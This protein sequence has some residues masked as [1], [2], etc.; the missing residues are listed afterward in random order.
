MGSIRRIVYSACSYL[1]R[2]MKCCKFKKLLVLSMLFSMLF[3]IGSDFYLSLA[4]AICLLISWAI[5]YILGFIE[6]YSRS[7]TVA[8]LINILLGVWAFSGHWLVLVVNGIYLLKNC[9]NISDEPI[10]QISTYGCYRYA[11]LIV[12]IITLIMS[13][14][15]KQDEFTFI[16]VVSIDEA[17]NLM[18]AKIKEPPRL[19]IRVMN[20]SGKILLRYTSEPNSGKHFLCVH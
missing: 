16:K 2:M 18:K 15:E 1:N 5:G 20:T 3:L 10:V 17:V 6:N 9:E 12:F 13:W 8:T 11:F 19:T 14:Y 4:I 7:V